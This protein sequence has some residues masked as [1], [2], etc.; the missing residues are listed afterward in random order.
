M[1]TILIAEDDPVMQSL[2]TELL[3]SRQYT[4]HGTADGATA[5]RAAES[6]HPDLI[7]MDMSLPGIT[8]FEAVRRIRD[9]VGT[10]V[11]IIGLSAHTLPD[12][13]TEA[14]DAGCT[15]FIGKPFSP[16]ALLDRIGELLPTA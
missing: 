12:D 11:P 5:V 9:S 4:V 2:L 10:T 16:I 6:L 13:Y 8:G 14:Y 15:A 7:V 3:A 1:P